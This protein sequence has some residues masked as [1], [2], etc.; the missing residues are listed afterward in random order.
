MSNPSPTPFFDVRMRGF[1]TRTEVDDV[2]AL[3]RS[4]VSALGPEAVA[5]RRGRRPGAGRGR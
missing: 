5:L 4:R 2:V 1:P 3:I